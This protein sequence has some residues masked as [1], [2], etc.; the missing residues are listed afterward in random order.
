MKSALQHIRDAGGSWALPLVAFAAKAVLVYP[1]FHRVIDSVKCKPYGTM[2]LFTLNCQCI[3][4]YEG[5]DCQE[6]KI[7]SSHGKCS[8][9]A[10]VCYNKWMGPLCNQCH[11]E[12]NET[13]TGNCIQP[14]YNNPDNGKCR[15]CTDATTCNSHGTCQSDGTCVCDQ[16][17]A[18]A[19]NGTVNPQ[20]A[21]R[22]KNDCTNSSV[23]I[24]V[25]G[26]FCQCLGSFCGDDC[27]QQT[28]RTNASKPCHGN[29]YPGF[30]ADQSCGG[31]PPGRCTCSC[32]VDTN[33]EPMFGDPYCNTSCPMGKGGL[34]CGRRLNSPKQGTPV[35]VDSRDRILPK[36]SS[37]DVA[38]CKCQCTDDST[39]LQVDPCTPFCCYGGQEIQNTGVCRCA[40]KG[41]PLKRCCS[42]LPGYFFPETGCGQYC[43]DG[44]TCPFASCVKNSTDGFSVT[45]SKCA[46]N[47]KPNIVEFAQEITLEKAFRE[48]NS[49]NYTITV[50]GDALTD[51]EA[52]FLRF[53]ASATSFADWNNLIIVDSV[54]T[55]KLS[56]SQPTLRYGVNISLP[57]DLFG[58]KTLDLSQPQIMADRVPI[59]VVDDKQYRYRTMSLLNTT[60][61]DNL[62]NTC[63]SLPG[64][65]A[66]N[67]ERLFSE[68]CESP[69]DPICEYTIYK[70]VTVLAEQAEVAQSVV[71]NVRLVDRLRRG[72]H[73]CLAD[74]YPSADPLQAV[75]NIEPCSRFC[76]RTHTCNSKGLCGKI[77]ECICDYPNMDAN[78]NRCM[79]GYYPDPFI[80]TQGCSHYVD[81]RSCLKDGFMCS[82]DGKQ[83]TD[84]CVAFG[85]NITQCNN[86]GC[87]MSGSTG[88]CKNPPAQQPCSHY[89]DPDDRK[90]YNTDVPEHN[91]SQSNINACNGH[92]F[93]N[94]RGM[95]E[96]RDSTM[97]LNGWGPPD[98]QPLGSSCDVPCNKRDQ[99][100]VCS[101]NGRCIDNKCVCIDGWFGPECDV[102]C[103]A[104]DQ[105]VYYETT[106]TDTVPCNYPSSVA[107]SSC[108]VNVPC[109]ADKTC[110]K[111]RCNGGSCMPYYDYQHAVYTD[112]STS[113][114]TSLTT[115]TTCVGDCRWNPLT[116][117]CH[118][119]VFTATVAYKQC[120]YNSTDRYELIEC[121]G[122][123]KSQWD[124]DNWSRARVQ[125]EFGIFCDV[126]TDPPKTPYDD[127]KEQHGLCARAQCN[128]NAPSGQ[129]S[130]GMT[131]SQAYEYSKSE[132]KKVTLPVALQLA[133][134]SCSFVGCGMSSFD[135]YTEQSPCGLSPPQI[136]ESPLSMLYSATLQDAKDSIDLCVNGAANIT[137]AQEQLRVAGYDK[138]RKA[139][140]QGTLYCSRG[141]CGPAHSDNIQARPGT[142]L[143]PADPLYMGTTGICL[144]KQTANSSTTCTSQSTLDYAGCCNGFHANKDSGTSTAPF[145]GANCGEQCN[146]YNRDYSK[147]SCVYGTD[148]Q[149]VLGTMCACRASATALPAPASNFNNART[150][151]FCGPSCRY[152]CA[153]IISTTAN[154]RSIFSED[155][156]GPP[157]NR[158][159]TSI[160][161]DGCYDNLRPCS[162][163]GFCYEPRTGSCTD[164]V[165]TETQLAQCT[166]DGEGIDIGPLKGQSG[167]SEIL[168][169]NQVVLWGGDDCSYQCPGTQNDALQKLVNSQYDLLR[170]PLTFKN[171]TPINLLQEYAS[172][173]SDN[174]CSGHGFCTDQSPRADDN[175]LLCY[176]LGNWG[177]PRC[178]NRCDLTANLQWTNPNPPYQ[179]QDNA[180]ITDDVL[181]TEFD[182]H[183]CGPRAAC[184]HS[185]AMCTVRDDLA[186]F[187]RFKPVYYSNSNSSSTN[188]IPQV[189]AYVQSLLPGANHLTRFLKQWRLA[190]VGT[191]GKCESGWFTSQIDPMYDSDVDARLSGAPDVI[192]WQLQRSCDA[193]YVHNS[194]SLNS[195]WCCKYRP[196]PSPNE[197]GYNVFTDQSSDEYS[198]V[199]SKSHGGCPPNQCPAFAGGSTC[200]T[201]VSDSFL[202]GSGPDGSSCPAP[203]QPIKKGHCHMC[204]HETAT[205]FY[206]S[207]FIEYDANNSYTT[208]PSV[209]RATCQA[210]ISNYNVPDTQ[211][212]QGT[213]NGHGTCRGFMSG[214]SPPYAEKSTDYLSDPT[215]SKLGTCDCDDGY[216]GPTC[217]LPGNATT[218][219][220]AGTLL[221]NGICNCNPGSCGFY[222][223]LSNCPFNQVLPE[224]VIQDGK[225]I[226]C[227]GR[228]SI[229]NR[230]VC[231]CST[232]TTEYGIKIKYDSLSG[233]RELT[234]DSLSAYQNYTRGHYYNTSR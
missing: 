107:N 216:T 195:P 9:S 25:A 12:D 154:D 52:R 147:G 48:L 11:A 167:S 221:A 106:S 29:G 18:M 162:G 206:V 43:L 205:E 22:C 53:N 89:C 122:L 226:A 133:G 21:A 179:E 140:N 190:F 39:Q 120:A 142:K 212:P 93:C 113:T 194:T 128:C 156:C 112:L 180:N 97:Q 208:D 7:D 117:T 225:I 86:M 28:A 75:A 189:D 63:L 173:Y 99:Q 83:C 87:V 32:L 69:N 150:R 33:C 229:S 121:T 26:G 228:G 84:T 166:C 132:Y 95:C 61:N 148:A 177:G 170:S 219:C 158:L 36:A 13:C 124:N 232:F 108:A 220:N 35:F 24:C 136:V 157:Y 90:D 2:D 78:C 3:D 168:I 135:G 187:S 210:C 20:C 193:E 143:H 85:T 138:L 72:C 73:D 114:C 146:C 149:V 184:D 14:W 186:N 68:V 80:V 204:A 144:C 94:V 51:G 164:P 234:N 91:V 159:D 54:V 111:L 153:G 196:I 100:N 10:A 211:D 134:R 230:G 65:K 174:A 45:C 109:G 17:Y 152:Q 98:D 38:A 131:I 213:C 151:L 41:D 23:G 74:Y 64:C 202:I 217:A 31:D 40:G 222:C 119:N 227:A 105:Y 215:Q 37:P 104:T 44:I 171:A 165:N 1:W 8:G 137:C 169:P 125:Q 88:L 50:K 92:G 185:T 46:G 30:Q 203:G 56:E 77:G 214:Q 79:P 115:R 70:N 233:C 42:C 207:P 82:W 182:L 141:Q 55:L 27:S 192:K 139:A 197:T 188:E 16:G 15:F 71:Y 160:V 116:H 58:D 224:T 110:T 161:T 199:F 130:S 118:D 181:S 60:G 62:A 101:G 178:E 176:C 102:T 19:L 231:D 129:H 209:H 66:Y 198:F 200:R 163:H 183:I 5:Y 103:N 34:V 49:S 81:E 172:L 96:C 126:R 175:T 47:Q 127:W 59:E 201:C 145:Y 218:A 67:A 223:E 155:K 123:T 57:K 4:I 6:C 191:A 76:D